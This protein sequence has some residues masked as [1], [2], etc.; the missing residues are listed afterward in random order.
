MIS[1]AM[2]G[3][4]S[5][6]FVRRRRRLVA[7]T[8]AVLDGWGYEE[9]DVPLL[10]PFEALR[11]AIGDDVDRE[12]FRFV[13]RSGDLLYLRGDLTPTVAHVLA[14][15]LSSAELPVRVSYA[16]RVARV[17]RDFAR[18]QLESYEAGFELV[19]TR[20]PDADLEALVIAA[21]LVHSLGVGR[22]T[23]VVGDV[24]IAR[25]LAARSGAPVTA[26]LSLISARDRKAVDELAA[27]AGADASTR[28]ALGMLC[29]MHADDT[30]LAVL[31]GDADRE[32]ASCA[33]SLRDLLA[34]FAQVVPNVSVALDL[35]AVGARSY[36][37]G[38]QF[39]VVSE[40]WGTALGSG[41]RYDDL[42]G[43]FGP[44]VS[45][46]GFGLHIDRLVRAGH[47]DADEPSGAE[48]FFAPES[49]GTA[50]GAR[51]S[52]ERVRIQQRVSPMAAERGGEQ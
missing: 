52:G 48:M 40:A 12:L 24:R 39:S 2:Q 33:S 28:S 30:Q 8:L 50:L 20:G 29:A 7:D 27:D 13:D 49:I 23:F 44:A 31:A 19:G 4:V 21:D 35:S 36:Y 42:Y 47:G 22:S 6:F 9:L 26:M 37:T 41:G 51:Q 3:G 38:L 16:N 18:E 45:A 11:P 43:H 34:A 5:A 1:S 46:I 17:Q 25:R 10:S 15:R 32:L 14:Q